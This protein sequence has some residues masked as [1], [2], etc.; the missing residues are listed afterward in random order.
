MKNTTKVILWFKYLLG[1]MAV[2]IWL[3]LV[4][5]ISQMSEPF[6]I[7]APYCMGSTMLVFGLLTLVYK[8]LDYWVSKGETQQ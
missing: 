7:Q 5:K 6:M 4:Y 1:F 2:L 8:G 3:S